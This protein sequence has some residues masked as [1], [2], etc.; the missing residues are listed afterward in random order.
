MK[1]GHEVAGA[2]LRRGDLSLSEKFWQI[3][4]SLVL[5]VAL[6]SC[7]GLGMLYSAAGGDW[8]P[9]ADRQA[10]RLVVGL[11]GMIGIALVDIRFWMRYAYTFYVVVLVLLV[12]VEVKGTIG[13][14]A[15]RW[16]DLGFFQLQPSEL[17]KIALVLSLARYFHGA[18][19]DDVRRLPFLIPPLLM[20]LV[21]FALVL[22][23]P[24]LGTGLMLVAGTAGMLWMAG[25]RLWLFIVAGLGALAAIPVAWEFLHDYQRQRVLTF[26]NPER[27]PLGAG[28]HI[29]QSKIALGS[30]GL[31]GKGYMSG[32]QAHLN[33]LPEK[34]TDFIFTMLAEEFGMV[35]GVLLLSLYVVLLVYG[36]A[37]AFRCRHQFGR[38]TALGVTTTFFLYVFINT[39]MVMGLIPVVGVPLPLISYGGTALINLLMGFG[40][41]LCV[42]VHRD[43]QIGRHAA[44]DD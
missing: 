5:L 40:L 32:T 29:L 4:W 30:G 2:R 34:Q 10:V 36:F 44:F 16:I 39:A 14:G 42:F 24:D 28:Y 6:T 37:I 27:D 3:S 7:V 17:M 43:V 21:P 18:H 12:A 11:I 8:D 13:M 35:G 15:Q 22:K 20:A 41:L 31:F 9:W 25:V 19:L 23:Q 33:F 1:L 26:L 38:L